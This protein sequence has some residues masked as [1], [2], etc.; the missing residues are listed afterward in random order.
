MGVSTC[1]AYHV[2]VKLRDHASSSSGNYHELWWKQLWGSSSPCQ[3]KRFPVEVFL[4][5]VILQSQKSHGPLVIVLLRLSAMSL[6]GRVW[7][8][9]GTMTGGVVRRQSFHSAL[10]RSCRW[11]PPRMGI[12][13]MNVIGNNASD[14]IVAYACFQQGFTKR[15]LTFFSC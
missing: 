7:V 8:A 2:F 10:L 3:R 4:Q 14:L 12:F 11:C 5:V 15:N 9:I 6:G 1:S 13:K